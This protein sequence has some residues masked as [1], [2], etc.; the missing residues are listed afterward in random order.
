LKV[1]EKW[2]PYF[3]YDIVGLEVW[4]SKMARSGL[5]LQSVKGWKFTF[6]PALPKKRIYFYYSIFGREKGISHDYYRAKKLYALKES[7]LNKNNFNLFE[8]DSLKIDEKYNQYIKSRNRYYKIHY[9]KSLIFWMVMLLFI[10]TISIFE[11]VFPYF[12]FIP[13]VFLLYSFMALITL[14]LQI[15]RVK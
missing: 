6:I 5:K 11:N 1:I 3:P 14:K 4:L 13:L 8:V 15:S 9:C 2:H 10:I 12:I 7:V